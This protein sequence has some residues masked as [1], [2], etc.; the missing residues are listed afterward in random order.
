MMMVVLFHLRVS[1]SSF[2]RTVAAA[3]KLIIV[4][5]WA[6]R[7][8]DGISGEAAG[9]FKPRQTETLEA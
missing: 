6:S 9:D 8:F 7:K 2:P 5:F 1:S 3:K 4:C